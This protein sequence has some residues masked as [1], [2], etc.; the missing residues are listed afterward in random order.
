MIRDKTESA[1]EMSSLFLSLSLISVLAEDI[2]TISSDK[3]NKEF[4]ME[5]LHF[6][7]LDESNLNSERSDY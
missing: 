4:D 2:I 3:D 5:N 6:I 1:T 7:T